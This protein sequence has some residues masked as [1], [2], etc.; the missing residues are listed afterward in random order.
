MFVIGVALPGT[1][2]IRA[3]VTRPSAIS[4]CDWSSESGGKRNESVEFDEV[5]VMDS[6][7]EEFGVK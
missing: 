4:G 7:P 1:P 2:G 5:R 3:R 6:E